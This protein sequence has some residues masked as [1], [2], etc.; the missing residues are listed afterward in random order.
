MG[1]SYKPLWKL[2]IDRDMTKGQLREQAGISTRQLAK[3]GKG[4]DVSTDVLRKICD[5]LDCS[6]TDI[7]EMTP[8]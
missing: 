7:I 5:V 4:E 2:L 1:M 6:L 3:M 8:D